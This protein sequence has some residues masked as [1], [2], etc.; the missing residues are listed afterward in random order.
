MNKKIAFVYDAIWPYIKGGGEKRY[1]EI[2]KRLAIKGHEVH[3]YGMKLWDGSD[4]I[5]KEGIYLHGICPSKPLY[6]KDGRRS[7]W[8]AI[9]FGINCLKLVK[10]DF[11]IIDCCGFPYFS[12]F[13]CKL[14]CLLKGKKLNSTWHE[15]WGKDYWKSYLGSLWIFGYV[16]EKLAVKIPDKIIAVSPATA[17]RIR[18][19]LGYIGTIV[20]I[21]NG[22]NLE[23]IKS[24]KPSRVKSD[25]VYAGRLLD[26]KNVD[27]LIKAVG[28]IKN[29][30][31]RIKCLIIGD[32]PEKTKLL[33]LSNKL[34][35]EKN[36]QFT[37]FLPKHEDVYAL[38]KS[39]KVF[40]LPSTREGFGIV[41]I[42]AN[43]C[44]IP[45]IT[46]N[47]KGNAAKDLI[48]EGKNG[49]VCDLNGK[50][51][52]NR[53]SDV[54]EKDM[55]DKTKQICVNSAK[56]YDWGEIVNNIEEVYLK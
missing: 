21:P 41:V 43:A 28:L 14:V 13:T 4:V 30:L 53:I 10:E 49:Y 36:I 8:Q 55:D 12:L 7:I 38:I 26:F 19:E 33:E 22:V 54:F 9:C 2:A 50:E 17:L 16:V 37:G 25:I 46:I 3:L 6:T 39:S 52:T 24:I 5:C 15:V 1:Y 56:K 27:L 31:P 51:M 23:E 11:D 32:G 48:E 20:T 40:V 42:E 47:C 34:K 18:N 45:V 29:Q 44:G 35:L